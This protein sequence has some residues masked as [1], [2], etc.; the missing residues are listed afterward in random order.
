MVGVK[1]HVILNN[2]ITS[3]RLSLSKYLF[4]N[5][6]IYKPLQDI[7][8]P[9]SRIVIL[10]TFFCS[11]AT[12]SKAQGD[13]DNF[14]QESIDDSR[15]LI[16]AYVSPFMKS[17]SL[18]LNQGW[19]NT[20]KP[21]KLGGVDLTLTV[22][23]MTI[24]NDERFY[25]ATK[26]G[27]Q[28]V[29]LVSTSPN[30][31]N[32]PTFF[33]PDNAPQFRE[34]QSGQPFS[35]PPGVGMKEEIGMNIMPVPIAHLGVGL[36]KNTDL[37]IRFSPKI[38]VGDGGE[39]NVF[40]LG[41]MHDLKQWIPGIKLM[42]FDLSGF[43]GYTKLSLIYRYTDGDVAGADQRGEFK[44][45]ATTIQG[46]ISK[47]FSVLTVYGGLGYN[48]AKSNLA[49][50]GTFDINDDGDFADANERDPLDLKFAASGPRVTAGFRLKLAVLTLGADY[51]LQ[52]YKAF[53]VG[54]GISV[55]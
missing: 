23:S 24:P 35:G 46:V 1:I 8:K 25:D 37:K 41:V 20:A 19:Y 2:N 6:R 38:K 13:V 18:G 17:V 4:L 15:K 30:Y 26:L 31:P 36:P 44:I 9:F 50:K 39:F 12:Q 29:E 21:H 7:M 11:V 54:L 53:S 48:I 14:L 43:V 55:R 22:S 3:K 28:R 33:G 40:G 34:I 27:L 5:V 45:N 51:T 49:L 16:S 10:L 42:P 32:A 52:K 47:K